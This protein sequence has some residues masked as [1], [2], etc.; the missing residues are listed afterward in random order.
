[1][2]AS[3]SDAGVVVAATAVPMPE[4]PAAAESTHPS[5]AQEAAASLEVSAPVSQAAAPVNAPMAEPTPDAATSDAVAT[6]TEIAG[7]SEDMVANWKNIRDSIA[8]GG[9][10]KAAPAKEK[11]EVRAAEPE[12]FEAESSASATEVHGHLTSDPKAIASIVDSVLAELRPKIV[13]E[14]AKKLADSKKE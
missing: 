4:M 10:A 6:D 7:G 13:E 8:S 11:E 14:I 2:A 9:A 3:A 1:M 12:K 5:H